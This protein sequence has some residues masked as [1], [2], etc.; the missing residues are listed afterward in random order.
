MGQ[1]GGPGE[2]VGAVHV[3]YRG[4]RHVLGRTADGYAIWD[5]GGG[6]PRQ[7]FPLSDEGWVQAWQSYQQLEAGWGAPA[8]GAPA[9]SIGPAAGPGAVMDYSGTRYGLGRAQD[10]YVI[11][12]LQAQA[13]V[14][15]FPLTDRGWAEAWRTYQELE[16]PYS[17]VP[18]ST[19][20]KGRPIPLRAMRAG[21]IIGGAFKLYFLNFWP[22]VGATALIMLPVFAIVGGVTVAVLRTVEVSTDFGTVQTVEAPV[23]ANAVG[24]VLG[25]FGGSLLVAALLV[26]VA[27]AVTGRPPTVGLALREGLRRMLPVLWVTFLLALIVL[28]I[29]IP[30]LALG[31][32]WALNPTSGA[33][34]GLYVLVVLATIVPVY[35]VV[36][37]FLF[38]TSAVV[39]EG[40]RG[41][42]ALRRSWEL[43]RGLGWK[44][45]GNFLLET[46]VAMGIALPILLIG[47]I[48]LTVAVFAGASGGFGPDSFGTGAA[49]GLFIGFFV[50]YAVVLV[51]IAPF[52]NVAI[53]LQYFDARVR[54]ERFSE[55]VLGAELAG[56]PPGGGVGPPWPGP[57]GP[58]AI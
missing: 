7:T 35:F 51:L 6:P 49:T 19:W 47:T 24:W 27:F 4:I 46:L 2:L 3:D 36:V 44:V 29:S 58:P 39:I 9:G 20:Q 26:A 43:V 55:Q 50:L 34:L 25:L 18:T 40:R 57:S 56:S 33:L 54:K 41:V 28:A 21:Q 22:L 45:F 42:E 53:A 37:R 31:V 15:G 17:F 10:Q 14:R 13:G 23:W 1:E 38:A 12:D 8:A 48:I 16:G 32:A 11:W 30:A 5:V 52:L